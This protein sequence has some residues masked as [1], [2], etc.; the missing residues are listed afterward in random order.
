MALAAFV[1]ASEV[2]NDSVVIATPLVAPC[3][4]KYD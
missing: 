4:G 1:Q 2:A 3:N